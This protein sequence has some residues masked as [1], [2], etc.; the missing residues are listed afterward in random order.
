M[1]SPT[2][3]PT[4]IAADF[5]AKLAYLFDPHRYKVAYGG[6]GG[7]KSWGIARALLLIGRERP[8]RVLCARETQK[9]IADS[10]HKLLCDQIAALGLDSFY[11]ITKTAIVG[12]NG[13][14]F[15][16]AGIKQN[17][18]NLK[19]YE[20]CDICW[21]EEAQTVSK[22]SWEVLIP[23]IRKESSEIWVSFNPELD[24][25]DTY[26]R[27]V[28]HPPPNAAVEKIN[29]RDNP[30]FPEV[31]RLEKDHLKLISPDDY[32]HVYE[33]MCKLAVEG[34]IYRAELL[35]AEKDGR[36]ARV[37]YDPIKPVHT[38]WDL[39]FA[40]NTAIWFGQAIG[41]EFRLIDY[42]E[43]SQQSLQFYLKTLQNKPYVYGTDYLP[44][45]ARAHELGTGRSIE[46]QMKAAGRKVQV[47]P[48]LSIVDGIAAVRAIFPKCWFDAD[49]CADGIQALRHYRYEADEKLGTLKREPLHDWASHPADA[50]R[51]F[52]VAIKEVVTKPVQPRHA[53]SSNRGWA[54]S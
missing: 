25:D 17:I 15:I 14:E 18:S 44:H 10:V 32:E 54:W 9:S 4:E 5:P 52:A 28:Q 30:W 50:F 29:W 51:C 1:S 35:T 11:F 16:F 37:P 49:N 2:V 34:A 40:D 43:G 31:L 53:P 27:F 38:F 6:R 7:A 8:T 21:V 26:K 47:V 39:G 23:T 24:T 36:F 48:K 33:G 13:T 41:F 20:G 42:M 46:E 3:S 22:H 12:A 19:S 45:D